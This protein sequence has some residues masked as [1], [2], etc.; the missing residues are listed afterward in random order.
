MTDPLCTVIT[1]FSLFETLSKDKLKE[2]WTLL[3]QVGLSKY[4]E[5]EFKRIIF[6]NLIFKNY[7]DPKMNSLLKDCISK[8]RILANKIN[9]RTGFMQLP[10][11]LVC[12]TFSYLL[13][14]E[15]NK[16]QQVCREHFINSRKRESFHNSYFKFIIPTDITKLRHLLKIFFDDGRYKKLKKLILSVPTK[17]C[18]SR[19]HIAQCNTFDY[20]HR[21]S[22]VFPEIKTLQIMCGEYIIISDNFLGKFANLKYIFLHYVGFSNNYWL[23]YKNKEIVLRTHPQLVQLANVTVLT[24]CDSGFF[25]QSKFRDAQPI[26]K[27]LKALEFRYFS[28]DE[29]FSKSKYLCNAPN[30]EYLSLFC[31]EPV[32]KYGIFNMPSDWHPNYCNVKEFYFSLECHNNFIDYCQ[33]FG[34]KNGKKPKNVTF[35]VKYGSNVTFKYNN[36]WKTRTFMSTNDVL[37]SNLNIL[38]CVI[39][40]I[41]DNMFSEFCSIVDYFHDIEAPKHILVILKLKKDDKESGVWEAGVLEYNKILNY[42]LNKVKLEG[43]ETLLTLYDVAP[44]LHNLDI[45]E[46]HYSHVKIEVT[47]KESQISYHNGINSVHFNHFSFYPQFNIKDSINP[48]KLHKIF[49]KDKLYDL[50]KQL[51]FP[52]SKFDPSACVTDLCHMFGCCFS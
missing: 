32:L 44:K 51:N 24:V 36:I 26:L 41:P 7:K 43:C 17:N 9:K 38:K 16:Q 37:F 5:K 31:P 30:L 8:F 20:I 13:G 45:I 35:S 11:A 28:G 18:S 22:D 29:W 21:L 14:N 4:G 42:I 47:N 23:S 19:E 25:E 12:K 1:F 46:E 3:L 50:K 2:G 40:T 49:Y 27:N 6:N 39:E 34:W 10:S 15:L 48:N 33:L 52:N